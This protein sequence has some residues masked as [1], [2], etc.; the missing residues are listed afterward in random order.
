MANV[1]IWPRMDRST[2]EQRF[3]EVADEAGPRTDLSI[4]EFSYSPVGR[5]AG[6]PQFEALRNRIVEIAGRYGFRVRHGF[7]QD[8]DPGHAARAEFDNEVFSCI[9]ELMPMNWSEAG[10]REIWSWCSLALLPDVTHWR[11]KWVGSRGRW[12]RERWIGTD[13]TRH[14]WGRHWWRAVQFAEDQSQVRRLQ[15]SEMNQIAER[16]D[17]IGA[18]PLLLTTFVREFEAVR[19]DQHLRWNRDLLRDA[20][21]R[22]L[23]DMAY[24]DDALFDQEEMHAWIVRQMKAAVDRLDT[25]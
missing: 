11:W 23:R 24:L 16:A 22:I 15:E 3:T 25:P 7:A 2:A 9:S 21:Q 6:Q 1:Y 14:T 17:T 12:N 19:S 4:D 18:N 8:L 13:L 10:S 20:A 5:R